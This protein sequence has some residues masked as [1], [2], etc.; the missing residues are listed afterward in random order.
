MW[1][2]D[3]LKHLSPEMRAVFQLVILDAMTMSEVSEELGL[4]KPRVFNLYQVALLRLE[5]I[6]R[7]KKTHPR[8]VAGRTYLHRIRRLPEPLRRVAYGI[9]FQGL[10]ITETA[11]KLGYT[12]ARVWEWYLQGVEAIDKQRP[13]RVPDSP[14]QNRAAKTK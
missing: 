10:T 3:D 1:N 7:Q 2:A 9:I 6:A 4:S 5:V 12:P 13:E 14:V 8:A 11:A